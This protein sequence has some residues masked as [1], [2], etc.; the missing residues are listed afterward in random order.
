MYLQLK[1]LLKSQ[2]FSADGYSCS[3]IDASQNHI[4]GMVTCENIVSVKFENYLNRVV[5]PLPIEIIP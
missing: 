1:N 4:S 3:P 5:N 2:S